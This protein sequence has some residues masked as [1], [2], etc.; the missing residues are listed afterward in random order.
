[1]SELYKLSIPKLARSSASVTYV[2][3]TYLLLYLIGPGGL[4]GLRALPTIRVLLYAF[5][6]LII[7]YGILAIVAIKP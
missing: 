7:P 2:A 3:G 1:M 6:Y 5:W 4:K